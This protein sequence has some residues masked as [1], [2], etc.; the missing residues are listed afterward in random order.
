MQSVEAACQA[1]QAIEACQIAR[2]SCTQHPKVAQKLKNINYNAHAC[3]SAQPKWGLA[4]W[5][6]ALTRLL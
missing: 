3:L 1:P 2:L 4:S 5:A 6:G